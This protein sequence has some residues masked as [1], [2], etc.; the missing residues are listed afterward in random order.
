MPRRKH[1]PKRPVFKAERGPRRHGCMRFPVGEAA[2]LWIGAASETQGRPEAETVRM[3][4][5]L[6]GKR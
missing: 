5:K 6:P 4:R 2:G 1:V 3:L